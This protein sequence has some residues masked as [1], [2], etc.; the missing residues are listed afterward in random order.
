MSYYLKMYLL[1]ASSELNFNLKNKIHRLIH[2]AGT[3]I[4]IKLFC[5]MHV[6]RGMEWN[7]SI[8][9]KSIIIFFVFVYQVTRF[10]E[11][12]IEIRDLNETNELRS[13]LNIYPFKWKWKWNGMED[14][15]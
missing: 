3:S 2:N 5:Y 15:F 12:C 6:M 1:I 13:K 14:S 8:Y 11:M 9:L 10:L 7:V 4:F